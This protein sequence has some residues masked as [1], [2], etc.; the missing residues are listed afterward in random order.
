MIGSYTAGTETSNALDLLNFSCSYL[1]VALLNIA[2]NNEVGI[3]IECNPICFF[4]MQFSTSVFPKL[5]WVWM[6]CARPNL[7]WVRLPFLSWPHFSSW[8][9]WTT[10]CLSWCSAT[11]ENWLSRSPRSMNASLSTCQPLRYKLPTAFDE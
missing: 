3:E 5:S 9:L 8:S 6:C 11:L 4:F 7:V 1:A 2:V 10:K